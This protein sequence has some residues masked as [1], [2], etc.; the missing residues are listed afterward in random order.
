M[1]LL[2]TSRLLTK[3]ASGVLAALPGAVKREASNVKRGSATE[4]RPC[5]GQGASRRARIGR[6]RSLVF[7]NSLR[8]TLK[9]SVSLR[10]SR[11]C[12]AQVV[13]QHPA[14]WSRTGPLSIPL[15][16]HLLPVSDRS[17]A[18][19]WCDRLPLANHT[20]PQSSELRVLSAEFEGEEREVLS[21][22]C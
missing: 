18:D 20:P 14:R 1:P 21:S 11:F 7:L 10:A 5:M 15:D 8:I 19:A 2:S 4:L 12:H 16:R 22:G 17:P 9:E 3:S 6:V 13:C